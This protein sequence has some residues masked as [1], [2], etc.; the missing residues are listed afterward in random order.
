[1][2]ITD[3]REE[4]IIESKTRIFV[5]DLETNRHIGQMNVKTILVATLAAFVR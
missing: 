2:S 4:I 3:C 5:S 1:M